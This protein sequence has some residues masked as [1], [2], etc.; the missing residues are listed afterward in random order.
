[1]L[2]RSKNNTNVKRSRFDGAWMVYKVQHIITGVKHSMYLFLMRDGS[3]TDPQEY[4][5]VVVE[6]L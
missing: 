5:E 3:E 6:K 2:F 4:K 1:M